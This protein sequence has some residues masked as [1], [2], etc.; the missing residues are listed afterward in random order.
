MNQCTSHA[1]LRSRVLYVAYVCRS[2][3]VIM[4]HQSRRKRITHQCC[5][6]FIIDFVTINFVT[7][8]LT[9]RL[10]KD[11]ANGSTIVIIYNKKNNNNNN[12]Y[13]YNNNYNCNNSNSSRSVDCVTYILQYG[14]D[15]YI[16]NLFRR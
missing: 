5:I 6:Y 11:K 15:R 1:C 12:Y 16:Q 4:W 7:R 3:T 14:F 2:D 10:C 13:Y 8:H 9:R